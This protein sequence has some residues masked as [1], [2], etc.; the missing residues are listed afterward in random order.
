MGALL[1]KLPY[2]RRGTAR[3]APAVVAQLADPTDG[4]PRRVL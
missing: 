4:I 3:D 2:N 1:A